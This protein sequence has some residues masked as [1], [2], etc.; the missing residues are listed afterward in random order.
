[1][2]IKIN[3]C[4]N[5]EIRIWCWNLNG[6]ISF[7]IVFV[8]SLLFINISVAVL[9]SFIAYYLASFL[10]S[11]LKAG[12]IQRWFYYYIPHLSPWYSK[13]LVCSSKR[14]FVK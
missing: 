6:V 7:G 8:L 12:Y 10:S 1:M 3:R 4:I 11:K 13:S 9:S 5:K 14:Y 2:T